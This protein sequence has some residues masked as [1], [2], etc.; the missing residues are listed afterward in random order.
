MPKIFAVIAIVSVAA[1]AMVSSSR[2]LQKVDIRI[3][4]QPFI[5]M[6]AKYQIVLLG[7]AIIVLL[8][9][10]LINPTGFKTFFHPGD[11]KAPAAAVRWLGIK[12][13]ESW[14]SV[15]AGFSVGITLVTSLFMLFA[16]KS[17]GGNVTALATALPWIILFSATNSFSEEAI[18]RMGVIG[19]LYQNIDP[20]YILLLSAILFGLPHLKGMPSGAVGVVLAGI[21]GWI[22]AKSVVETKGLFWAVWIHFIQDV[23]IFSGIAIMRSG[24]A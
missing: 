1:I 11:I 10:Y 7:I 2:L 5:N 13:H 21:L 22:L 16:V 23:V 8:A 3:S 4:E 24:K 15:G 6:Q 17:T 9:S 18:F 12:Q 14:M 19:P 20:K